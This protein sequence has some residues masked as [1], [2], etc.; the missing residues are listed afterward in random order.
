MNPGETVFSGAEH[1]GTDLAVLPSESGFY[2]GF[3]DRDGQP[4]SRETIYFQDEGVASDALELIKL[5]IATFQNVRT[6]DF[7]R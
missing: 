2:V 5:T 4:Y 6:L 1:P 3:L 7:V